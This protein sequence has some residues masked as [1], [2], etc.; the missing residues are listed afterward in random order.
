MLIPHQSSEVTL[1]RAFGYLF[2]YYLKRL[3]C[4]THSPVFEFRY[5]QENFLFSKTSIP[6][7]G[8]SQ[9]P[10][11]WVT[12]FFPGVQRSRASRWSFNLQLA[13]RLRMSGDTPPLPLYTL[14]AWTRKLISFHLF[15]CSLLTTLLVEEYRASN[16]DVW[17]SGRGLKFYPDI[18]RAPVQ[19]R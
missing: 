9:P 13:P 16:D 12:W 19:N 5:K 3:G 2:V 8:P 14:R 7:P 15:I 18:L 4:G 17:E 10:I 1:F 11:L 6:A